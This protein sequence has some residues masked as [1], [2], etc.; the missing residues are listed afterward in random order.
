MKSKQENITII[1]IVIVRRFIC[2][3]GIAIIFVLNGYAQINE[4]S[5]E[6]E[7]VSISKGDY[8][9]SPQE[10]V[11]GDTFPKR[12]DFEFIVYNNS[13][14][15]LMIGS[16][17][18]C[19]YHFDGKDTNCEEIGRFLMINGM[20]TIPLYTDRYYLHPNPH[21]GVKAIW[22]I[23]ESS[24]DS[25]TCP[26]FT[27]FLRRWTNVGNDNIKELYNYLKF[28]RFVYVPILADYQRALN[29]INNKSIIDCIIYPR[30]T[31]EVKKKEPFSVFVGYSEE[32][33]HDYIYPS[34]D[35]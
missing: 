28:S 19:Y 10:L 17:T 13:N 8:H 23:I 34:E 29:K 9:P 24:K 3:F 12:I 22:G 6:L 15:M 14:K 33:D 21:S 11:K 30:N 25:K 4:L 18:R 16:N 7:I 1:S 26:I 20:D 32:K 31:L 2:F 5:I 35:K 27:P